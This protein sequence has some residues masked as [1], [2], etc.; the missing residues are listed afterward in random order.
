MG[1]EC[2]GRKKSDKGGV[3]TGN[4]FDEFFKSSGIV[5]EVTSP[6]TPEYSGVAE[7]KNRTFFDLIKIILINSGS[8]NYM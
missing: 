1:F 7:R 2:K 8:P 3:Y 5:H 4:S 6:Y